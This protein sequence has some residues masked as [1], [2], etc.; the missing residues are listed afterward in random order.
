[1]FVVN[2]ERLNRSCSKWEVIVMSDRSPYNPEI[3]SMMY[4][5][6][7]QS[8]ETLIN[9]QVVDQATR[10]GMRLGMAKIILAEVGSGQSDPEVLKQKVIEAFRRG[11]A[12]V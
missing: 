2:S 1:V 7:D 11:A 4:S 3:L 6:L 10:Q 8:V 5:V 9:G 12:D